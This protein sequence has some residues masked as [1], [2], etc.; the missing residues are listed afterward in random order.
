MAFLGDRLRPIRVDGSESGFASQPARV[1][2]LRTSGLP[3]STRIWGEFRG[4]HTQLAPGLGQEKSRLR[5]S[6]YVPSGNHDPAEKA[7][8]NVRFATSLRR[9]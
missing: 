9:D 8:E 1:S 3:F 5:T 2:P 4:H 7:W 6:A